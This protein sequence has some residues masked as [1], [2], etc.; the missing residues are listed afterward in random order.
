[1]ANLIEL[2]KSYV[3]MLDE[4]YK[5]ASCTSD[6]DGA[7][8]LARQGANANELIIPMLEMDGLA[9]YDRNGGYVDGDVK[10]ENRTVQCNFDLGRMFTVDTM[11]NA[12]T[13][14]LAFGRL[15]AEFIRT[16]VVPELDA[17]RFACYAGKPGT[18]SAEGTLAS[19]ADVIAAISAAVTEMDENEVPSD[20][21][22]LR[23]TSTLLRAI[24]DMDSYKSREVLESFASVKPL[25]QRRFYTAIEQLSGKDG[26]KAGGFRKYGKHYVKCAQGDTGAL[27]VILDSGSVSG[28]QIKAADVTPVADPAYKPAAGDY[29]KAVAGAEINFMILHTPALIQ[30]QKHVAPKIISPEQNQT[31]DAWKYGYRNVGIA[32]VYA[33]KLAGVFCHHKA[34]GV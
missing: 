11:D 5:L 10:M 1:M 25:P 22:H 31:G 7:P 29:V 12:E 2:A 30:F 8:E 27:E 34:A 3:P 24:K 21:R 26:E 4:V 17:F 19:G 18:S 6:L 32:D 13:A 9:D 16:K 14:G 23:I 33:N 28:A 20:Q 15:A